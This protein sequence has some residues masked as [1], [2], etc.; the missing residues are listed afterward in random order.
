MQF[1][2]S[3]RKEAGKVKKSNHWSM[4]DVE[5]LP[6]HIRADVM[7][8]LAGHK[9]TKPQQDE[10]N[11]LGGKKQNQTGMVN[12]DGPCIVRITRV[13]QRQLDDDNLS[14]GCKELRDAITALLGRKD[15]SDKSGLQWQYQQKQGADATHIEIFSRPGSYV[16]E[17]PTPPPQ[18]NARKGLKT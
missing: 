15:D 10:L 14:G 2:F 9:D 6:E 7:R 18:K 4:K 11:P 5:R 13:S 16:E 17:S 3:Y 1:Y 12:I 8:Q